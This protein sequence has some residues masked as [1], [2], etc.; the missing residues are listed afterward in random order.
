MP[1]LRGRSHRPQVD[2]GGGSVVEEETEKGQGQ[3]DGEVPA[4]AAQQHREA[5]RRNRTHPAA[6]MSRPSRR[7]APLMSTTVIARRSGTTRVVGRWTG[8]TITTIAPMAS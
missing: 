2:A 8:E 1:C 6:N 3:G 5:G 4:R 7:F